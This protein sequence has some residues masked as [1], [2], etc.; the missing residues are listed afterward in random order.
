MDSS[1]TAARGCIYLES[2]AR[3]FCRLITLLEDG[4]LFEQSGQVEELLFETIQI[5]R[6]LVELP[7]QT[8]VPPAL[9]DSPDPAEEDVPF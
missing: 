4:R 9:Q 7:R 3:S 5:R 1:I 6:E 8:G 2:A